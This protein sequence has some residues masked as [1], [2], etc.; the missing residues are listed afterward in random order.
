MNPKPDSRQHWEDIYTTK[1]PEEVSWTQP[2]AGLSLQFIMQVAPKRDARILDVGGGESPLVNAL[3][4]N[5]YSD[6]TVNDISAAAMQRAQA[7]L[8]VQACKA[9]WV[10]ADITQ[11]NGALPKDLDVWHDR[12]V[13]HFLTK[14]VDR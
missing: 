9:Q 2:D 6:V 14:T 13:F 11:P 5:G 10:E 1:Q 7:R 4:A 3:L 8:G 12:A